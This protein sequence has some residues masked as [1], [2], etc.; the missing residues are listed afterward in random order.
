MSA[1]LDMHPSRLV[2]S[3]AVSDPAKFQGFFDVM[4][5]A[6]LVC[7]ADGRMVFVN[8]QTELLS[9]YE[10]GELSGSLVEILVPTATR[11]RHAAQRQQYGERPNVRGMG[12]Q[13][14][15]NLRC[16]DGIDVPVDIALSPVETDDG[17]RIVAVIRDMRE[18]HRFE[19]KMK[20]EADAE[21][22]RAKDELISM[23][24]HEMRSPLASIVGF[25]ELLMTRDSSHDQRQRYL[26]TMLQEARRLTG[27]IND[28][29]DMKRMDGTHHRLN[30]SPTDIARLVKRAV[31]NV[32][33]DPKI[34]IAISLPSDLPMVVVDPDA[35]LQV[36]T[37]LISNAR[38]Y[39]P[40]GGEILFTAR[41][42][43]ES[44]E[45][46]L[47]DHGLGLQKEELGK[48]F[49]KFYRTDRP[50]LRTIKGTGLGLAISRRIVEAH[51]GRLDAQS[52]GPGQG[53]TFKFTLPIAPASPLTADVLVVEDDHGFA[54]LMNAELEANGLSSTWAPE[55][56]SAN[57]LM[58]KG[59][60]K[61]VVLDLRLPGIQGEEFLI[62]LR[63]A[64][65]P[66]IPVVI[67][68]MRPVGSEEQAALQAL[69]ATAVFGKQSDAV[70]A[71][72]AL[73]RDALKS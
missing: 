31:D 40:D 51:G 59:A 68:T 37:N 73:L 53:T 10:R 42:T 26:D 58:E 39:S 72:A 62:G 69:G 55:A 22:A 5:D 9:G 44:I 49:N 4:P 27:L 6:V 8:R 67:V 1:V 19:A 48:L 45:V 13:L 21:M 20:L 60:A 35:I 2:T 38:K 28:F 46:S 61:A 3:A 32:P 11:S 16:K 33:E 17:L 24:S 65:G 63:T 64:R 66:S 47:K 54:K 14:N 34:P 57:R 36:L 52:D 30:T 25:T 70:K 23:V 43:G 50:Q 18:R 15:I 41:T 56:D 29:L 7:D 12:T 71:A